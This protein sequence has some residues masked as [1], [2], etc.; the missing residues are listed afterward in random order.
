MESFAI[1]GARPGYYV[2]DRFA[3]SFAEAVCDGPLPTE[4]EAR[5]SLRDGWEENGDTGDI[6][7]ASVNLVPT[8]EATNDAR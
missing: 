3:D 7:V 5:K 8:E 1:R 2:L 4:A 6:F